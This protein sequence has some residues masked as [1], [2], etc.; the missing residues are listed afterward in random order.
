MARTQ[1]G[2]PA[3]GVVRPGGGRC[4]PRDGPAGAAR[5]PGRGGCRDGPRAEGRNFEASSRCHGIADGRRAAGP[6]CG[7]GGAPGRADAAGRVW[8][9]GQSGPRR[10]SHR[11]AWRRTPHPHAFRGRDGR[12]Q[13][14]LRRIRRH[15]PV[16]RA[17]RPRLEHQRAQARLSRPVSVVLERVRRRRPG[18][19]RERQLHPSVQRAAGA[20]PDGGPG[21]RAQQLLSA[22]RQSVRWDGELRSSI[23]RSGG[24]GHFKHA[25]AGFGRGG[26]AGLP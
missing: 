17:G 21:A 16:R 22:I 12:I 13:Q 24:D 7:G 3:E 8:R 5:R 25:H 19:R 1:G 4:V 6:G 18:Q 26:A 15:G 9:P 10:R 14:R 20:G 2:G 11:P 23:Q